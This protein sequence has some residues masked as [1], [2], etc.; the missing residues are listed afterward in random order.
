MFKTIISGPG[1][2]GKDKKK[3]VKKHII[4]ELSERSDIIVILD[5]KNQYDELADQTLY[6]DKMNPLLEPM[7]ATDAKIINA[8]YL[9]ETHCLYKMC[10]DILHENKQTERMGLIEES[11]QRLQYCWYPIENQYGKILASK[12]SLKKNKSHQSLGD[13][14]AELLGT[15]EEEESIPTKKQKKIVVVKAKNLHSDHI[16]ARTYM[17]LSRL[18][19]QKQVSISI[20]ADDVTLLFNQGNPSLFFSTVDLDHIDLLVLLNKFSILPR[21]VLNKI[22]IFDFFPVKSNTELEKIKSYFP[23][24][25]EKIVKLKGQEIISLIKENVAN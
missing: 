6:L 12:I 7:S 14:V 16:R 10:Q 17:L 19:Q 25:A 22:E 15:N 23:K 11:I 24:Q 3:Y 4:P 18:N 9:K 21:T 5:F 2:N 20:V 8:G 13:F 1:K